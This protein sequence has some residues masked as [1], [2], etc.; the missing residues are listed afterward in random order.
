MKL[1]KGLDKMRIN[2]MALSRFEEFFLTPVGIGVCI[3]L[4][5]ALV[6]GVIDSC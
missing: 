5:L 3:V 2:H 1:T 6:I 4:F